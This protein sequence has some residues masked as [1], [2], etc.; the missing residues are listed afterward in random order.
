MGRQQDPDKRG[1]GQ[2]DERRRI[3]KSGGMDLDHRGRRAIIIGGGIAGPALGVFLR[4]LGYDVALFEARDHAAGEGGFLT[5]SANGMHVLRA[6]G[7]EAALRAAA[8]PWHG[9]VFQNADGV[10]LGALDRSADERQFAAEGVVVKRADLNRVLD[11]AARAAGVQVHRGAR[12]V[13]VQQAEKNVTAQFADGTSATADLLFGCDGLHSTVRPMALPD[14]PAPVYT[15]VLDSG[16]FVPNMGWAP[17]ATMTMVFG[18]RALFGYF[19]ASEDEIFWFS[20][21]VEP[22]EPARE[23]IRA[24]DTAIL[25]A[26]L[27]EQHAED[28]KEAMALLRAGAP[29]GR[30]PIY[31]MPPL[32]R[33]HHDRVCL[34]GDAAHATSPHEGHGASLALEDAQV[35]ASA[36]TQHDGNAA[37]FAAFQA[38]RKP[39]VERLVGAARRMGATGSTDT[40]WAA[41]DSN[42]VPHTL[43]LV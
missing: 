40:R 14:A 30:W 3:R 37:A 27:L 1:I 6:L 39:R 10:P 36:L 21:I 5:L 24:A 25:R 16:G 32:A 18:R 26:E 28:P 38:A 34:L 22:V 20:H 4:H 8:F 15:G 35:L 43:P 42:P 33:W 7:C 13:H 23:S 29:L 41:G 2:K 11:A 17:R 19:V 9:L 31:D 12:L